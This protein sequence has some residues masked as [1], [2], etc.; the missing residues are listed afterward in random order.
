[1]CKTALGTLEH[2]VWNCPLNSFRYPQPCN[3][4]QR[5]FGWFTIGYP[6]NH[7]V[8]LH[9]AKTIQTLWDAR[10]PDEDESD[11]NFPT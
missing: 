5:R 9:L 10:Y 2:V 7:E 1:M 3:P 8:S 6:H 11:S 4:L